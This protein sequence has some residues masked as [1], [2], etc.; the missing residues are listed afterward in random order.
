MMRS[1]YLLSIL[2]ASLFCLPLWG[3]KQV[4][5]LTR[6][7]NKLY[8][9]KEYSKA[10]IDYRKALE[11]NK[12]DRT[13]IFN[14]ANVLYR[15][16]RGEEASKLYQSLTPHLSLFSSTEAADLTHNAGNTAF[17]AKQ[18]EQAIECYKESLRRRPSDEDTRYNLA[19]AQK[20]LEEQK[21]NGGGGQ[22]QKQDQD[23][24]QK[25]DQQ[26]DQQKDQKKDQ[27]PQPQQPNQDQMSQE[28]ANRILQALQK[29]EKNT[30]Q[31][32]EQAQQQRGR[33]RRKN[34]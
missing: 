28:T 15:T 18:L 31:M 21:K 4:R 11:V 17:R 7:G 6:S 33:S 1:K 13:T 25:K 16:D 23:K 12:S 27:K 8:R 14:L 30:R 19:L 20:L 32:L 26:Q 22:D 24:D 3:Q 34:W 10:E 9:S 29:D 5:D 2:F